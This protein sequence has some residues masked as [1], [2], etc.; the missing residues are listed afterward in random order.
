MKQRSIIFFSLVLGSLV[1]QT[2]IPFCVALFLIYF[3]ENYYEAIVLGVLIDLVFVRTTSPYV[4]IY[5]FGMLLLY[6]G[7]QFV[8]PYI[9]R[10]DF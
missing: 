10:N 1:F 3:Y 2:W 5:T 7:I 6:L 9:R 4:G 8:K